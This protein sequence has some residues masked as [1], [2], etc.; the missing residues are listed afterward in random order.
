MISHFSS[1]TMAFL[2]FLSV[3]FLSFTVR[4]VSSQKDH[5]I[6]RP[7]ELLKSENI[8]DIDENIHYAYIP[9]F[10]DEWVNL[11][12]APDHPVAS[13]FHLWF[14]C[15][16]RDVRVF[17]HIEDLRKLSHG[18]EA[19][20][21]IQPHVERNVKIKVDGKP[22]Q[23]QSW[24]SGAQFFFTIPSDVP[25]YYLA[26][27]KIEGVKHYARFPVSKCTAAPIKTEKMKYITHIHLREFTNAQSMNRN[28]I[29]GVV[30]HILYHHCLLQVSY[31]EIVIQREQIKI[32]TENPKIASFLRKGWLKLMIRN[33]S[34]PAPIDMTGGSNC[35]WQGY[36]EN[37]ALLRHWKEN[38][39]MYM[40][41]SDEYIVLPNESK[42]SLQNFWDDANKYEAVGIERIYSFCID[43]PRDKP[44]LKHL[45]FTKQRYTYSGK[46]ND[47]KLLVNPDKVGCYIVHWAGCGVPTH[48]LPIENIFLLHFENLYIARWHK[49]K[50]ELLKDPQYNVTQN[51]LAC[52]PSQHHHME[53]MHQMDILK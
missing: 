52:D 15:V 13:A 9:V 33:P 5:K 7:T 38:V 41:D 26:E 19:D 43:C 6:L 47:P 16:E 30:K 3:C 25:D 42:Y 39:K 17:F 29:D 50:E 10:Q 51:V 12:K 4:T 11:I 22:I 31:H 23:F 21:P 34:I 37:L 35:Y 20:F 27:I 8:H 48:R 49:S 14:R 36:T 44:E 24:F 18:K 53:N 28:I 32:F 1:M 45:S 40:M 46:L 2:G